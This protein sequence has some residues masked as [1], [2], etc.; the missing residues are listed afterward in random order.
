MQQL[1]NLIPPCRVLDAGCGDGKNSAFLVEQGYEVEGFDISRLA[2]R[3][4]RQRFQLRGL[5]ASQYLEAS[6]RNYLDAP[7]QPVDVLLSYG[8]YHCLTATS[9]KSDHLELM[10][11]VRPGGLVILSSLTNRLPWPS[12]HTTSDL[13]LPSDDEV[14]GL[15]STPKWRIHHENRGVI[16]E[17]HLPTIGEHEHS[18]VWVIGRRVP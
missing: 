8:L 1:P 13:D 4:L 9:R 5:N 12:G 2:L 16:N 18:V 17:H 3:A 7:R 10:S 14:V 15:V 6:V 11:L